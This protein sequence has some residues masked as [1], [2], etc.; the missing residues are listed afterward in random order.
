MANQIVTQKTAVN[1]AA[2]LKAELPIL[3]FVN[4]TCSNKLEGGKGSSVGVVIPNYGK[5]SEGESFL[6]ESE[7]VVRPLGTIAD[8]DIIQEEVLVKTKIKKVGARYNLIEK[9]L[10]LINKGEQVDEPRLSNLAQ[11]IHAEIFKCL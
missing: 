5:V 1:I 11:N 10:E 2:T 3:Q 7:N 9:Q 8:L 4:K 6:N